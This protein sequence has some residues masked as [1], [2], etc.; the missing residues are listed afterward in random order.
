MKVYNLTS[1]E[2]ADAGTI[3]TSVKRTNTPVT[4]GSA[5]MFVGNLHAI[6]M[7]CVVIYTPRL[8]PI[9]FLPPWIRLHCLTF[10]RT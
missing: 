10:Y 5:F 3:I 6:Y 9:C 1:L 4:L 2:H 7:P 8:P